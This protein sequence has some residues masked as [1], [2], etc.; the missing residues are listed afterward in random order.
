MAA[1]MRP[2]VDSLMARLADGDRSVFTQVFHLLWGPVAR[3]CRG[4]LRND[5]DADD[6]AQDALQKVLERASD[7]DKTR[8][9]LPWALAIAGWECRTLARKRA[10]RRETS[11]DSHSEPCSMDEEEQA[12]QRDLT[13]AALA[14]L[15]QL[16]EADRDTLFATYWDEAASVT[17]ATLRK[18]RQRALDHL[19]S[20]FRRI[21]GLG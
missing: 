21:Y 7:Y 19:R 6:A 3:F 16:S 1:G 18:R 5:A 2:E 4:M 20:S 8:A 12:V 13:N 9:A 15:G 14:A 10:R 11:E 17:G